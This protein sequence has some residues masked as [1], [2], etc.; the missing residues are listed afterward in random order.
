MVPLEAPD[1]AALVKK[2]VRKVGVKGSK[3]STSENRAEMLLGRGRSNLKMF[4]T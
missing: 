2:T 3:E 1:L 4:I